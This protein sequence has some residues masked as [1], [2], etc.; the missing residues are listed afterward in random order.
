MFIL[1]VFTFLLS[2]VIAIGQELIFAPGEWDFGI[3]TRSQPVEIEI[4]V[5]NRGGEDVELELLSTCDCL[6]PGETDI[7]VPTAGRA[8]F[9]LRFDPTDESGRV[10]KDLIVISDRRGYE[11]ILFHVYGQVI[12]EVAENEDLI[13]ADISHVKPDEEGLDEVRL[14]YYYSPACHSC[15]RFLKREI[16]RLERKL[17]L[18]LS[19]EKRDILTAPAYEEFIALAERLEADEPALPAVLVGDTLLLGERRIAGELEALLQSARGEEAGEYTF[20]GSKDLSKRLSVLPVALAGLLDGVNPCAFTTLIFLL[21]ALTLAGRNR[22]EIL[23]LGV[24]FSF[25]VFS[26]YFLIGLGLFRALR[27][28]AA[29]PMIAEVLRV[30]LVA[31]LL[32]FAGLSL[33]D[34]LLIRRGRSRD[35]VLQLPA[36]L[37]QRI[38]RSIRTRVKSITLATSALS[39]GFLVSV[40]ELACT[41]QVY[42]P[43][44]AYMARLERSLGVYLLL[45]IYNIGFILPLLVVFILVYS[46]IKSERIS[47]Y[48]RRH[49]GGLKVSLAALFVLLAVLTV[50]T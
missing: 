26:T 42:F 12:A 35:I 18:R 29:F 28:A 50:L 47:S 20:L 14:F 31:V 30:I 48:F 49:L 7:R 33:Y 21:S 16:P 44:L 19:V 27:L 36:L 37:K 41:G 4:V 22:R 9:T 34:A 43:T 5:E 39:L 40:F 13:D 6:I 15:L 23:L 1:I 25:S 10:D 3:L 46:G 8:D 32:L 11:K 45:G 17:G 38:H 2:P 24:F